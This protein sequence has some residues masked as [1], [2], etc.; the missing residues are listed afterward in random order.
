MKRKNVLLAGFA[1][2]AL[3]LTGCGKVTAAF[4]EKDNKLT[5]TTIELDNNTLNVIYKTIKG[6]DSFNSDV[7]E[8]LTREL[9]QAVLGSF[10][11][12]YDATAGYKVV[13]E[14]DALQTESEKTEWIKKHN[15]YNN[16]DHTGYKLSLDEEKTPTISEFETRLNTIKNLIDTQIVTSLW[17]EA[18]SSSYKRNN[19]FY[20]VLFARSIYEKL[21]DIADKLNNVIDDSH[22]E[23]ILYKNPTYK[24]HYLYTGTNS[25]N[26][27]KNRADDTTEGFTV[28]ALID[29]SYDTKTPEG[30]AKIKTVLHINHYLDYVNNSI[31]PGIITK[32]LIE[33]YIIQE[34]YSAIGNTQSRSIN[35][36]KIANND[37]KNADKFVTEFVKTYFTG[38]DDAN[39]GKTTTAKYEIATDSW[40]AIYE[41]I[42]S[43]AAKTTLA[44][45][46]FGAAKSENPSK[47][48]DG[49]EGGKYI[50]NF[51]DNREIKYYN[52]TPYFN[53][54]KQYSTLTNDSATN[55]SSNYS[56]FTSI[57]SINYTPIEGFAIKTDGIR[58]EDYTTEG[59]ETKDNSSLPDAAKNKLYSYGLVNE[60]NSSRHLNA[61]SKAYTK[62]S[63]IYQ[64]EKD[65]QMRSFLMKDTYSSREDSIIWQDSDNYYLIEIMDVITPEE[66]SISSTE[67]KE[68]KA[69]DK[70]KIES[71]VRTAAYTLAS[72]STYTTNALTFFLKQCN[73]SYHDQ[74]V[75]DYF[76][77]NFPNLFED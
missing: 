13:S 23:D 26:G 47:D 44:T 43:D 72:G 67:G 64:N 14:Y 49:H 7:K 19:R 46:T 20:E 61:D 6:N 66:I 5:N 54:V 69:E 75:Y 55:D 76:V 40:K 8:L 30:I 42:K 56:T 60:W 39:I 2:A 53:L 24:E 34:Q 4:P 77:E 50:E 29:G 73:I 9:A 1:C 31:L 38:T 25:F 11:V 58:I 48:K 41:D 17:S 57:D 70:V 63:F 28:G 15:A 10:S 12:E 22:A 18:N 21:Y 71:K 52:N 65:G 3:L 68:T 16:W 51:G 33:Q 74:D 45:N 35:Y 27:L 59:W 62:G 32:L 37:Q 36:I